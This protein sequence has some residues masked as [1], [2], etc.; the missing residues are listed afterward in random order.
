MRD[1][2]GDR[3]GDELLEVPIGKTELLI[4]TLPLALFVVL[5]VGEEQNRGGPTRE[6]TGAPTYADM[7]TP[8][9]ERSINAE[10][11]SAIGSSTTVWPASMAPMLRVLASE[12][13][14]CVSARARA[15]GVNGP[16]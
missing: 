3:E 9:G 6:N 4:V 11:T 1:D 2:D 14:V 12:P 13:A 8:V 10:P 5:P 7:M 16:E 15:G